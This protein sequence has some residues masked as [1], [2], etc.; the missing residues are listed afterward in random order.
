[1]VNGLQE[2][3]SASDAIHCLLAGTGSCSFP[4]VC[5][6][7]QNTAPACMGPAR[8]SQRNP[9]VELP[10]GV[11]LPMRGFKKSSQLLSSRIVID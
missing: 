11:G 1:M 6:A 7:T 9:V 3:G 8:A 2:D 4:S 10:R 5:V